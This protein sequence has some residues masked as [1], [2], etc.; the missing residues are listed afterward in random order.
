MS[1]SGLVTPRIALHLIE[2]NPGVRG[3]IQAPRQAGHAVPWD[4]ASCMELR[5]ADCWC[6]VDR[7]EV[8]ERCSEPDCCCGNLPDK[9]T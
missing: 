8:I 1:G 9:Q 5:C 3:G 7:G 6:L 4:N 2:L